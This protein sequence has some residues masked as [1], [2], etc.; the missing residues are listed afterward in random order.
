MKGK[1]LLFCAI[2]AIT[3]CAHL[4]SINGKIDLLYSHGI[5]IGA[6]DGH[7]GY[8]VHGK[9]ELLKKLIPGYT[10]YTDMETFC[11]K[12]AKDYPALA[13]RFVIG[14]SVEN[15]E[16]VGV[17]IASRPSA[18]KIKYVGNIHGDETVGRELLVRLIQHL[19]ENYGHDT[20]ITRLIDETEIHI[21]P[22]MNPDG[23]YR[24]R[25]T[26]ARN[27]DLNRNFPDRFYGQISAMQPE[28]KAIIQWSLQENFTISANL[29]GGDLVANY[30]YDG[31]RSRRSH[32]NTPTK[33]DALFRKMA[34]SYSMNHPEMKLSK[35]FPNGIT[36]GANWYVLY[37]GMQDWNYLHTNDKGI[38]IE[39]SKVKNPPAYTL[40]SYWEKNKKSLI[41]FMKQVDQMN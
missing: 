12:M 10:S 22:S 17:K 31:N 29:H 11:S 20:E 39:V 1:I 15:R 13:T 6:K 38:T 8:E 19:L 30:P 40:Q 26:N 4:P 21:L 25:R 34:L 37:G 32:V 27:Y 7:G 9:T 2:I 3:Q 16:L 14:K 35:Q 18:K 36:N 33:D 5:T 23:F 24:R 28:T 41:E